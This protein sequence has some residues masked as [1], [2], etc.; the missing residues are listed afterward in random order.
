MIELADL[1]VKHRLSASMAKIVLLIL[2]NRRVTANMIENDH[3]IVVD[4]KVIIHRIRR[5]LEGSGIVIQSRRDVGYWMDNE[6]KVKLYESLGLEAP[7][8]LAGGVAYESNLG[9]EHEVQDHTP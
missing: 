3:K 5:R 7:A 6:S 1:Q 8:G 2:E 9:V 4:A